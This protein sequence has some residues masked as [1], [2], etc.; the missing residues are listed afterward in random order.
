MKI[1]IQTPRLLIRELTPE[2]ET[3]S[4]ILDGDERLT[5]FVKKRSPQESK[6]VFKE[7]LKEYKNQ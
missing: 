2:D 3:L 4:M 5:Q 6:Q 7:T 1:I